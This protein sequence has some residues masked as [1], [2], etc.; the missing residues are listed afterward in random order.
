MENNSSNPIE[1][2]TAK[3]KQPQKK[4]GLVVGIL[5][6]IIIIL[7]ALLATPYIVKS[8]NKGMNYKLVCDYSVVE[9]FNNTFSSPNNMTKEITEL[10]DSI[11]TKNGYDKDP[12]CLQ[13]TYMNSVI[14]QDQQSA[15]TYLELME[16]MNEVGARPDMRLLQV[17]TIPTVKSF[18]NRAP[19]GSATEEVNGQG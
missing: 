6:F 13:I 17:N 18:V 9:K 2:S 15:K 7:L 16:K 4:R 11:K 5:V 19:A 12:T 10:S 1:N 3:Q 14:K 8:K